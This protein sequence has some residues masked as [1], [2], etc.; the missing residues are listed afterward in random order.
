MNI[1]KLS[2]SSNMQ[3]ESGIDSSMLNSM[4]ESSLRFNSFM[5]EQLAMTPPI[6]EKSNLNNVKDFLIGMTE[7]MKH[8]T[9]EANDGAIT[10]DKAVQQAV[11]ELSK[12]MKTIPL[13]VMNEL[14][15]CAETLCYEQDTPAIDIFS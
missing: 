9:I 2:V 6:E 12:R 11:Q 10:P 1:S 4:K 3:S 8:V 14:R 13:E 5:S 7:E 15:E